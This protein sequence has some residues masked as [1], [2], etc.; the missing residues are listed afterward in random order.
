MLDRDLASLYHVMTGRLNE[1]V[2]R[3]IARFPAEFMF[4]LSDSEM[5][6]LIANCDRFRMMK[7]S[8]WSSRLNPQGDKRAPRIRQIRIFGIM[9]IATLRAR[10]VCMKLTFLSLIVAIVLC[11][12][13]SSLHVVSSP[14]IHSDQPINVF[15]DFSDGHHFLY[16]KNS[17]LLAS[18]ETK[19]GLLSGQFEIYY[20][21]GVKKYWG[22]L[23]NKGHVVSGRYNEFSVL[24]DRGRQ[25]TVADM[26]NAQTELVHIM[27]TG[28]RQKLT[29]YVKEVQ[30]AKDQENNQ[31]LL[32]LDCARTD[33]HPVVGEIYEHDGKYLRVF[34]ALEDGVM[35]NAVAAPHISVFNC[36][37]MVIETDEDYVDNELLLPGKYEYVG[38]YRYE[39]INNKKRTIRAFREVE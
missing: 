6:E 4:Q 34:Q 33:Y 28:V 12:G 29:A 27:E 24:D 21:T 30:V 1:A 38:P 13:C 20:D 7:H 37:D 36:I 31:C 15:N 23:D 22:T 10:R 17:K 39:T 25:M 9:H 11:N 18:V 14:C 16:G 35:V 3:N 32:L 8:P 26:Q 19:D 2:K 5:K